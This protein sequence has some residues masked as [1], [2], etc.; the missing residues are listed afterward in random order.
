MQTL[1]AMHEDKQKRI[2]SETTYF[3]APIAERLG[4]Y[5]FK[6]QFEDL[7]FRHSSPQSTQR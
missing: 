2:A 7:A 5:D 6:T 1:S 3:Y 4:L